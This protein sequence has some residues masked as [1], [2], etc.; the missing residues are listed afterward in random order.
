[1]TTTVRVQGID[2]EVLLDPH[3]A[4][5]RDSF[6]EYRAGR[7][8]IA[9]SAQSS[10]Q[11]ANHSFVHE[12]LEALNYNLNLTMDHHTLTALGAGLYQAL[13]DNPELFRRLLAGVPVVPP[14]IVNSE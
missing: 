12:V 10:T 6:G 1:M 4:Q 3:I 9:L 7:C 14:P 2:Y 13:M 5:E 11:Q 8:Q